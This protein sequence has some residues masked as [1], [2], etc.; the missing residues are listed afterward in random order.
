MPGVGRGASPPNEWATPVAAKTYPS[1]RTTDAGITDS[2][3]NLILADMGM[4]PRP[5]WHVQPSHRGLP[6]SPSSAFLETPRPAN[7]ASFDDADALE[8]KLAR[9]TRLRQQRTAKL[10]QQLTQEEEK[11]RAEILRKRRNR[12]DDQVRKFRD[13]LAEQRRRRETPTAS[14]TVL[15]ADESRRFTASDITVDHRHVELVEKLNSKRIRR[16]RG[17]TQNGAEAPSST[18]EQQRSKPW[19]LPPVKQVVRISPSSSTWKLCSTAEGIRTPSTPSLLSAGGAVEP[20]SLSTLVRKEEQHGSRPST[21]YLMFLAAIDAAH[22]GPN[23]DQ[24]PMHE[25]ASRP[26][27]VPKGGAAIDQECRPTSDKAPILPAPRPAAATESKAHGPAPDMLLSPGTASRRLPAPTPLG[28]KSP[29]PSRL[30][31]LRFV[32][33]DNGEDQSRPNELSEAI[34]SFPPELFE[35]LEDLCQDR[36]SNRSVD[37]ILGILE[38]TPRATPSMRLRDMPGSTQT[39]SSPIQTVRPAGLDPRDH[40]WPASP[41]SPASRTGAVAL[42]AREPQTLLSATTR[43]SHSANNVVYGEVPLIAGHRGLDNLD[44]A[45]LS[46]RSPALEPRHKEPWNFPSSIPVEQSPPPPRARRRPKPKPLT[47]PEMRFDST[48]VRK[49]PRAK[50]AKRQ[51]NSDATNQAAAA[52]PPPREQGAMGGSGAAE[53]SPGGQGVVVVVPAGAVPGGGQLD[54]AQLQA[55]SVL[56]GQMRI[57]GVPG[58]SGH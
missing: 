4:L 41:R 43:I 57:S 42:S 39:P 17:L 1:A 11:R 25:Q 29:R 15:D 27:L 50:E 20:V 6:L 35:V 38:R 31:R 48:P 51:T 9:E 49:E 24:S 30:P 46:S 16:D 2:T 55:L 32:D 47:Q 8:R 34:H 40:R 58:F 3:A 21:P 23:R 12:L 13:L 33:T 22:G 54:P 5:Q 19:V 26:R 45:V 53:T 28:R 7:T 10:E 44:Q 14:T 36:R 37:Q 18:K 52:E 56:L